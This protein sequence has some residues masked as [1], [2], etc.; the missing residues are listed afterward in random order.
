MKKILFVLGMFLMCATIQ[1]KDD[2]PRY[3]E[4]HDP[5][6]DSVMTDCHVKVIDGL[7]NIIRVDTIKGQSAQSLYNKALAWIGRTYKNPEK[8]IKSQ[9]APSQIVFKGQLEESLNGTV[10]LQFKDGRYRMTINNIVLIVEP[11]LVRFVN[12]TYF[13]IE[14]RGEYDI[15]RGVRSQKWLLHDLY[16]FLNGFKKDMHGSTTEE[17]W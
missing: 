7:Y 4:T 5:N 13:T 9:V 6:P 10:E 1:A 14:D 2:E 12:R 16:T 15:T 17:N 8:V 3:W 11:E